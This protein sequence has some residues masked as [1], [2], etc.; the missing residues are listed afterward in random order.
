MVADAIKGDIVVIDIGGTHL[1]VGHLRDGV[2]SDTFHKMR[3]ATLRVPDPV[4]V[5]AE[6][7]TTHAAQHDLTPQAVVIGIPGMMDGARETISHSNNIPQLNGSGLGRRLQER[8]GCRVVL[9]HDIMLLL[10]GEW[11]AGAAEKSPAVVGLYFGTGIG[12]AYLQEGDPFRRGGAGIQAGHIPVMMEGRKCLCGNTD[13]VEAYASGHTLTALAE[14]SGVAVEEL[15]EQRDD[16]ALAEPL[17]RFITFQAYAATS[18]ATLLEP[19]M[20]LIGGGI[21]EMSEYP[22]DEFEATIRAHQQKP[23]PAE[24]LKIRW[25]SLGD[26][27]HLYGA[28]ALLEYL[29]NAQGSS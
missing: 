20:V 15:F 2:A 19:D 5:L 22:K 28:L 23:E 27:A 1:R 14:K 26:R 6:A 21:S 4:A 9:E 8:L 24:S 12:G 17:K 13:C 18:A 10:L 16:P 29:A 7:V 3:S 11:Y 25:A